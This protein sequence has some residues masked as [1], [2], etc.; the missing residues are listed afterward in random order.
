MSRVRPGGLALTAGLVAV[1]LVAAML[2]A[3]STI[4]VDDLEVGDC[5]VYDRSEVIASVDVVECADALAAVA[6][7]TGPVAALVVWRGPVAAAVPD[8]MTALDT[9]CEPYRDSSPVVVPVLFE[10]PADDG[11]SGL[12][13]ALGR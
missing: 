11:S 5:F 3:G 7:A 6:D 12:C 4:R 9:A 1:V 10:M 8:A 2:S 13:L